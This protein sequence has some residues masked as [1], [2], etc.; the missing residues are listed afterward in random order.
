MPRT[1]GIGREIPIKSFSSEI[2]YNHRSEPGMQIHKLKTGALVLAAALASAAHGFAA[3]TLR[4]SPGN[5][6]TIPG[7]VVP[8]LQYAAQ[9]IVVYSSDGS[10]LQYSIGG[11]VYGTCGQWFSVSPGGGTTQSTVSIFLLLMTC[12]N[13]SGSF[14]ITNT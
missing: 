5:L 12:P 14:T 7:S 6:V 2:S 9:N 8:S 4:V 3:A 10:P 1:E 13:A 11:Q